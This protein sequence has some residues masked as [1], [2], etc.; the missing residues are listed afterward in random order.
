MKT[1]KYLLITAFVCFI[2]AC[3]LM[4]TNIS[5]ILSV[6]VGVLAMCFVGTACHIYEQNIS[7]RYHST[8]HSVNKHGMVEG[9]R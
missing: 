4:T 8:S 1:I 7:T 3:Y 2:G 5:P 9:F 6:A